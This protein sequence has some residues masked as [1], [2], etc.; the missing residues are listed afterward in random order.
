MGWSYFGI[1]D[2]KESGEA[3]SSIVYDFITK[4]FPPAYITDGNA[5]S[6]EAQA[7]RM[8]ER[9]VALGVPVKKRFFDKS[10]G[11][12]THEYQFKLDKEPGKSAFDDVLD[13]LEEHREK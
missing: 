3:K 7:K 6:F 12:V 4:D 13:F 1:K 11:E 9:L 5:L 2:W 10:E 8:V